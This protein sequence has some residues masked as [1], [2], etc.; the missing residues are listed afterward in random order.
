M[1]EP[2]TFEDAGSWDRSCRLLKKSEH[3]S[4]L[5][6]TGPGRGHFEA[7]KYDRS[8]RAGLKASG[9]SMLS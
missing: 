1:A 5:Q 8:D 2:W 9:L 6:L 3:A 4:E 7:C